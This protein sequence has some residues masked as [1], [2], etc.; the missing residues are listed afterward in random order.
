MKNNNL[1]LTLEKFFQ[2]TSIVKA[3]TLRNCRNNC[4][5]IK[6]LKEDLIKIYKKYNISNI[7]ENNTKFNKLIRFLL[8]KYFQK[9]YAK[10]Q[11]KFKVI[12]KDV[13]NYDPGLLN[14][15]LYLWDGG[16]S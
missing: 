4:K 3:E 9:F 6:A 11:A 7:P 2:E 8:K 15:E 1:I 5:S 12:S 10:R 16:F 14:S 13:I